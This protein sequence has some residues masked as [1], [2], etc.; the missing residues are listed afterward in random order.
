[1]RA[2]S[3]LKRYAKFSILNLAVITLSL[4]FIFESFKIARA[5]G[6]SHIY[7]LSFATFLIGISLEIFPF[8]TP[9]TIQ[10]LGLKKGIWMTRSIGIFLIV[11][12][13]AILFM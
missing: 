5:L 8:T 10:Y 1:M 11:L 7:I 2:S 3:F 13:G 12:G 6:T 9:E 4:L